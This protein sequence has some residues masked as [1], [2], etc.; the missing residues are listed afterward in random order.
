MCKAY[1]ICLYIRHIYSKGVPM[2]RS[3]WGNISMRKVNA[4]SHGFK[5]LRSSGSK[6]EWFVKI[7]SRSSKKQRIQICNTIMEWTS[8][9]LRRVEFIHPTVCASIWSWLYINISTSSIGNIFRITG[10]LC[11]KFTGHRTPVGQCCDQL[12]LLVLLYPTQK[13][14]IILSY[15]KTGSNVRISPVKRR[16]VAGGCQPFCLECLE[17]TFTALVYLGC[18]RIHNIL[19]RSYVVYVAPWHYNDDVI[20][21]KHFPRYWPFVRGIHRSPVDSS[22]EG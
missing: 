22:H 12:I 20:K 2:R 5:S 6:I 10:H 3:K 21:W 19:P 14:Y 9:M 11:G 16:D 7:I 1:T 18:Y 4:A 13:S 15:I 8:M 17:W